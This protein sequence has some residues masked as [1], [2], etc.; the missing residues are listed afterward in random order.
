MKRISLLGSTGSIGTQ[1]LEVIDCNE[2]MQVSALCANR[3][4]TAIEAQIRRYRPAVACMMDAQAAQDLKVRVQDTNTRVLS[5]MDGFV[6]A[7]T[8]PTVDTVLTAVVGVIGL[9]PTI[10]AIEAG[11]T[12]ALANKET[13]VSGG[14]LVMP[15]A[16]KHHCPILP[17][18]SEHSAIFQCLAGQQERPKKLIITASGGPFYGKSAA[19]ISHVPP[20][21]ALQHPNWSM[22]AKITIDSA[23]MMNKGFEVIEAA[24][25]YDMP[26]ENIDVVVHRESIVHSMVQFADNSVIAQLSTP[27]MKLPISYALTYPQRRPCKVEPLD[28]CALHTLSFQAPDHETFPC[29]NLA[30]KAANIGGTMPAV[31]NAANEELVYLYLQEKISF[32]DIAM[33]LRRMMELHTPIPSPA[34]QDILDSDT[35]AREMIKKSF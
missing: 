9:I 5:G 32:G 12:I 7:A 8:L 33:Q 22:G 20:S 10:A 19:E 26:L 3:N 13:L 2:D 21:S 17:V 27:D 18:D 24:W 23:T 6:E 14:C 31:L 4:V 28:F 1:T 11:K 35:W 25:L 34:L 30:K 29:L 15:L 16:K